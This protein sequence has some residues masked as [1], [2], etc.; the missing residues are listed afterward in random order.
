MAN[1]PT[2][3]E[4]R[5]LVTLTK[6]VLEESSGRERLVCIETLRKLLSTLATA[7]RNQVD[8]DEADNELAGKLADL[9]K[10][11]DWDE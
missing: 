7:E 8:V 1:K 3:D 10:G 6:E 5:E 9:V 2:I 4:L 11:E